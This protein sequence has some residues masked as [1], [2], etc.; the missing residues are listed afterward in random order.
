MNKVIGVTKPVYELCRVLEEFEDDERIN[1]TVFYPFSATLESHNY[2]S[3]F[4]FNNV[5]YE[6]QYDVNDILTVVDFGV[7]GW[8][9]I[10]DEM[11][12][13][14]IESLTNSIRNNETNI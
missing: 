8:K 4:T 1:F 12:E 13:A 6:I 10:G 2:C 5:Y 14:Y 9:E 3:A 11:T 7:K